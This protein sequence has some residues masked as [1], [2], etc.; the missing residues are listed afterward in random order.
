MASVIQWRV[1][2][3]FRPTH[4]KKQKKIISILR[5]ASAPSFKHPRYSVSLGW[6]ADYE[7]DK[8]EWEKTKSPWNYHP[9]LHV[10]VRPGFARRYSSPDRDATADNTHDPSGIARR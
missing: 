5:N 6:T 8:N 10:H 2:I 7:M 3:S 4:G 9:R 1:N